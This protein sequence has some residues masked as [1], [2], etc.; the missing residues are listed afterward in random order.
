MPR[1]RDVAHRH[2]QGGHN[3]FFFLK[4]PYLNIVL[5]MCVCC[6]Y[7]GVLI[8][9]KCV[10]VWPPSAPATR[11][12]IW[13]LN[14]SDRPLFMSKQSDWLGAE[15]VFYEQTA[16]QRFS[17][18]F[19]QG[20]NIQKYS[21]CSPSSCLPLLHSMHKHT[22]ETQMPTSSPVFGRDPV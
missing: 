20:E 14:G 6:T 12:R 5:F 4:F 22:P 7:V 10:F 13:P 18:N 15:E 1:T 19:V 17:K 21:V 2:R 3:F 16:F 11:S 9:K 8:R